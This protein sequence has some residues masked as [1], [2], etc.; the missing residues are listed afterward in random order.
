MYDCPLLFFALFRIGNQ[1]TVVPLQDGSVAWIKA[2]V[3]NIPTG[4]HHPFSW[5]QPRLTVVDDL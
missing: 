3:A 4:S 5:Q 2:P 1:A